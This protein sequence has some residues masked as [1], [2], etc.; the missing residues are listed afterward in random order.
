MATVTPPA[1]SDYHLTTRI[2]R[3]APVR[4]QE[5]RKAVLSRQPRE[6]TDRS[7]YCDTRRDVCHT[8]HEQ[9]LALSQARYDLCVREYKG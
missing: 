2:D 9:S 4:A 5:G 1:L 6:S 8:T 3:K 7:S